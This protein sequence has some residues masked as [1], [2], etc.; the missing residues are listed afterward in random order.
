MRAKTVEIIVEKKPW[1]PPQ[2]PDVTLV[3]VRIGYAENALQE[4]AREARGRW[5]PEKKLW[6]IQYGKIKGAVLE[7]YIVLDAS[8][9]SEK[10]K[11]I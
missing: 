9:S 7:K 10:F 2:I 11:S 4:K 5:N 1:T 8:P 6:F 3:P